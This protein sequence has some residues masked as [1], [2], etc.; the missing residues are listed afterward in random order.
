M[1]V[2]PDIAGGE[3]GTTRRLLVAKLR[4]PAQGLRCC[5]FGADDPAGFLQNFNGDET[6]A[7]LEFESRRRLGRSRSQHEGGTDI[8]MARERNL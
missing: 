2:A 3:R 1:P 4:Q 6:G 5:E 8:R 7:F